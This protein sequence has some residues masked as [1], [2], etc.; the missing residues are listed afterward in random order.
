MTSL[1]KPILHTF[2]FLIL[3]TFSVISR[4]ESQEM[5]WQ[6]L[7]ID[8]GLGGGEETQRFGPRN[9]K[10]SS[11]YQVDTLACISPKGDEEVIYYFI[12]VYIWLFCRFSLS[13]TLK[14][15]FD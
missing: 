3:H 11:L 7:D 8:A 5:G 14:I 15:I 4:N 12:S 9:E 1:I 2:S 10:G 6:N 13:R